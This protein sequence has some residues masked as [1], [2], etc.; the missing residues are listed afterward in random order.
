MFATILIY[1]IVRYLQG[2]LP[3]YAKL[4]CVIGLVLTVLYVAVGWP[5]LPAR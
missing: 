2:I 4:L 3:E 5:P 1:V